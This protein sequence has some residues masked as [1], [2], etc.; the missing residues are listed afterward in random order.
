MELNCLVDDADMKNVTHFFKASNYN[1]ISNTAIQNVC[2]SMTS[3]LAKK[4]FEIQNNQ[5]SNVQRLVLSINSSNTK[6]SE[7]F[8][9]KISEQNQKEMFVLSPCPTIL[10][11]PLLEKKKLTEKSPVKPLTFSPSRFLNADLSGSDKLDCSNKENISFPCSI[12]EDS[13]IALSDISSSMSLASTPQNKPQDNSLLTKIQTSF[14]N[15]KDHFSYFTPLQ[16]TPKADYRIT[17]NQ[18]PLIQKFLNES[19]LQTP[20][21]FK[22]PSNKLEVREISNKKSPTPT[23]KKV[24]KKKC[25][26]KALIHEHGFAFDCDKIR[27]NQLKN[28]DF[29]SPIMKFAKLSSR[30]CSKMPF[31]K[32]HDNS[33]LIEHSTVVEKKKITP[34]KSVYFTRRSNNNR[35]FTLNNQWVSVAC[36]RTTDQIEMVA[37]AKRCLY[38]R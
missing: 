9:L 1:I 3:P 24:K 28:E 21:P 7:K 25:V 30:L 2:S 13:G 4:S 34:V 33:N 23:L 6:N 18:T 17:T 32:L 27:K 12:V 22:C 26:R 16:S 37:A 5:I 36:G 14:S 19:V 35:S 15:K 31:I 29:A 8:M 10:K 38:E 20:S 11:K